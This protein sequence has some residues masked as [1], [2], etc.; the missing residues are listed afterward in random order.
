M[1]ET[2]LT[3]RYAYE[4]YLAA[5]HAPRTV[6]G[7]RTLAKHWEQAAL[8]TV[9]PEKGK[10]H[11]RVVSPDPDLATIDNVT[12]YDFKTHLSKTLAQ[13]S[14]RKY[15][16]HLAVVLNRLGPAD[17]R[18]KE[19]LGILAAVPFAK[20]PKEILKPVVTIES[21]ELTGLYKAAE[22][23][24]WPRCE[25]PAPLWWQSLLV[26]LFNIGLR[27][28]DFLSA[29]QRE[30]DLRRGCVTFDAEKT[31]KSS[32]LPLHPVVLEHLER[33]WEPHREMVWPWRIN[34]EQ[35]DPIDRKKTSL[36]AQWHRLRAAAGIERIITPHDLR[37]TCGSDLFVTSPAAA[38]EC[39]QH[40]SIVT[41]QRSYANCSRQTREL[42]L[43]RN[44]PSIFTASETDPTDGPQILRF[45]MS[46]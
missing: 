10:L 33:I 28:I 17:H 25:I 4:R 11:L 8:T 30:F 23:A 44:Q 5:H 15:L 18:N 2:K 45:P 3:L 40:S 31:G 41:T 12:L 16:K 13:N 20:P 22:S 19:G 29:R 9:M 36:Y 35:P 32:T 24:T 27:R 42:M 14:V 26:L 43:A 1:T 21:E 6:E 39:L 37:R 38:S 34:Q 7:Y 46:G